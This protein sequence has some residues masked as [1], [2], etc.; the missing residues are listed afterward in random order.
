MSEKKKS[1][2]C[3]LL[4]VLGIILVLIVILAVVGVMF[5]GSL[6]KTGIQTIGSTVTK[7]DITVDDVSL[8]VLRGHL[9][10]DNLV[11]KNPEGYKTPSAFTLTKVEVKLVPKSL[12]SDK[13]IVNEVEILAPEV[14]YEVDPLKFSSNIGSIQKNVESFLPAGDDKDKEEKEEK[15][16]EKAGKKIQIDHVLID[17]GKIN[18]SATIAGGHSLPVPLPKIEMNDIG[19]EKD[20]TSLE[21]SASILFR[22][23][24][25]VIDAGNEAIKSIGSGIK[26]VGEAV[27]SGAKSIGN[28]VGNILGLKDKDAKT[29]EKKEEK[30]EEKKADEGK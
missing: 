3:K 5:A 9:R 14:T 4:K 28:A 12:L 17:D 29:E 6:I 15:K 7:C 13:I 26:G 19:K 23:F 21:A 27:G 18:V 1:C 20:V 25:G 8:S 2:K 10:I 22:M 30:T 24:T 16:E 11:V